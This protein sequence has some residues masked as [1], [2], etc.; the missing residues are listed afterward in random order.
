MFF[1]N[2]RR[3]KCYK[4]LTKLYLFLSK[5]LMQISWSSKRQVEIAMKFWTSKLCKKSL[6][7]LKGLKLFKGVKLRHNFKWQST[8]PTKKF[9]TKKPLNFLTISAHKAS[10]NLTIFYCFPW[11]QQAS[12]VKPEA[13]IQPFSYC[14]HLSFVT[15]ENIFRYLWYIAVVECSL[16]RK[17]S[18]FNSIPIACLKTR[19]ISR[20]LSHS[21]GCLI[22]AV[23]QI[24]L[25]EWEL[26]KNV[27]EKIVGKWCSKLKSPSAQF[28]IQVS[29]PFLPSAQIEF[30]N[31][32][33][34]QIIAPLIFFLF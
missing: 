22:R 11:T 20:S 3:I 27:K 1:L 34:F 5:A 9:S 31:F 7:L 23:K 25:D 10:F 26:K 33:F 21:W 15:Y 29:F 8:E 24:Y 4:T 14:S 12:L 32:T 2:H 28:R 17:L 16:V 19:L 6:E 18:E 30:R 13:N